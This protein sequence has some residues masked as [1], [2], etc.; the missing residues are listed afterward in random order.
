MTTFREGIMPLE[1]RVD[2]FVA[3]RLEAVTTT[4]GPL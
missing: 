3:R 1:E 2:A 4:V